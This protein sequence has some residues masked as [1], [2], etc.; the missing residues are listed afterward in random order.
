VPPD[1]TL[2]Q[3]AVNDVPIPLVPLAERRWHL[4]LASEQ[5][6]QELSVVFHTRLPAVF[7]ERPQQVRVPWITDFD[8]VRTL[9]SVQGGRHFVLHGE[10]INERQVSALAQEAIRLRSTAG[11]VESAVDTVL[12]SPATEI[13]AWYA[14]W[15]IRLACSTARLEQFR[16]QQTAPAPA[17]DWVTTL[18]QQQ[19]LI[20]ERLGVST[21]LVDYQTH[22]AEY[23]QPSD[24]LRFGQRADAVAQR[25]AF[26]GAE[27][28]VAIV[29]TSD[30][31]SSW[32]YQVAGALLTALIGGVVWWHGRG[33]HWLSLLC[34]WPH[35]VGVAVGLAWWL[36]AAPSLVGWLII[37]VSLWGAVRLP[38]PSQRVRIPAPENAADTSS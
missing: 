37:A 36:F 4:R 38:M 8:V 35:L 24:K 22:T 15:A 18:C 32:W 26:L 30:D 11:L 20:A 16:R 2:I 23:P 34:Q 1:C 21:T 29:Q 7:S 3:A 25:Y 9:W 13:H 27:P 12:D 31:W 28:S 33:G 10:S 19:Q 14:P 17:P 6:P 5:L